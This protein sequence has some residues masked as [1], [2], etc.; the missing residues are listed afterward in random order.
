M[1]IVSDEDAAVIR[2]ALKFARDIVE[3]G[4]SVVYDTRDKRAEL[5]KGLAAAERLLTDPWDLARSDARKAR[6]K[7]RWSIVKHTGCDAEEAERIL[8]VHEGPVPRP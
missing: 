3:D 2:H 6:M 4:Y 7:K 1:I 8:T 5:A